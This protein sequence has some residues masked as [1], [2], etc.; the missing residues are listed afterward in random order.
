LVEAIIL[1]LSKLAEIEGDIFYGNALQ[2]GTAIS[3]VWLSFAL[4]EKFP[5]KDRKNYQLKLKH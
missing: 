4:G 1:V 2:I 5:K 3:V